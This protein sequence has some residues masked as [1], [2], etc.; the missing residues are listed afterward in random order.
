MI[1]PSALVAEGLCETLERSYADLYGRSD[2]A[3]AGVASSIAKLVLERLASSDALYH[4]ERHTLQVTLVGQAILRGKI[5]VAPVP[6]DYWLHFTT[7]TLVHDI[8]YLRGICPGDGDGRF[9]IDADGRTVEAPRGASDAFLTPWHIERGKVFVRHRLRNLPGIDVERIARA[10]ELTRFPVPQGGDHVETDTE[11]GLVRAADLIGQ[12][13]D[14]LYPKRLN[15]LFHEFMETGVARQLGYQ[16]AADVAER[17][18]RFFWDQVE[19]Y[20]GPALSHLDRTLEGKRWVA[21]L[22]AHVFVEEHMRERSG[23]QRTALAH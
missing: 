11:A 10:I 23:P 18:P 8:G 14:P 22:Y 15:A 21:Q 6:P 12:L 2:P 1:D 9:V 13:G 3:H 19:P 7:A 20:L 5:L 4:D 17:Y 16:S